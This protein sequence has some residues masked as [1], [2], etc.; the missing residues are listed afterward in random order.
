MDMIQ[1]NVDLQ[2]YNTFGLSVKAEKFASFAAADELDELVR[3]NGDTPLLVLGGGS[4]MLLTRDIGGL[5][6]RNEI[7][8]IEARVEGTDV[9][10]KA[11]G[12]VVWHD[13][14]LFCITQNYGGIENLSLIPGSVGAAPMQNI[15]AYGVEIKDVFVSLEAYELATGQVAIFTKDQCAFA[16][17]DSVFKQKLKGKYIITA[18]TLK[19]STQPKLNT[20]YGAIH[21]RLEEMGVTNPT[22][23]DV[24]EAVIHIRQTKLPDPKKIG[25]S[26]SFF[27]NPVISKQQ[28]EELKSRFP[29]VAH[30][31]VD[32]DH[33]KIAAGW[34]I[35]QAGWK[36]KTIGNYGV[37]KNQ[38]LVLVN[39]GGA[40][41][42]D[43]YQLSEDIV[44]SIHKTYGIELE[45]EVNVI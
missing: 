8:G 29:D 37:H 42:S 17:R 23:K 13:L 3:N 4:N 25:N 7:Q 14:V 43:I 40:K 41:G 44:K 31:P 20:S 16:Y 10:V 21:S 9:Y 33:V 1:K 45:R 5:V 34:L 6:L 26:G 30:Y 15:G 32:E 22:I 12:G 38:A 11:G 36:G 19:L 35:D 28:F 27:K 39:Y 18:V 24:S 2:P